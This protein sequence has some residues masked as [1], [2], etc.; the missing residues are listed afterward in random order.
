MHL[1]LLLRGVMSGNQFSHSNIQMGLVYLLY[2]LYQERLQSLFNISLHSNHLIKGQLSDFYSIT[3]YICVSIFIVWP[4]PSVIL[5]RKA[6]RLTHSLKSSQKILQSTVT[7]TGCMYT[8]L[9]VDKPIMLSV[10][11]DP[12]LHFL[13]NIWKT[14][15]KQ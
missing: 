11:Y 7:S 14:V 13:Q 12:F 5:T 9:C 3:K 15:I 6:Q 2:L 4:H 8:R 10:S 1:D